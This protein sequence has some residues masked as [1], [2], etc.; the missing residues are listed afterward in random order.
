MRSPFSA[1]SV[2]E[3]RRPMMRSESR[4]EETSGLVTTTATSAWRMACVAPRSMP[5]GLSQM[6]QSNFSRS[7]AMTRATPS[8]VSASLSRVCEAGRIDS[9]STR[10]SRISACTSLAS[11]WTTLMRSKTTRR[12]APITRSRL[13]RPTSKSTT[14]TFCPL[15]AS[16]APRA[17][18][19]VVLPTPPLPDVTTMT[20]AIV[21]TPTPLVQGF[22]RD[23]LAVEARL[24]GATAE[25]P[26]HVLGGL[27]EPVDG[28]ELGLELAA[29]DA[30]PGV[31]HRAGDGAAAQRAVDMDRAA[32]DD[33]GARGDRA[34]D[35]HVALGED[36]RLA[37]AH[38]RLEK[39]RGGPRRGRRGGRRALRAR[40]DAIDVGGGT[41][42]GHR[43]RQ[44]EPQLLR[45]GTLEPHDADAAPVELGDQ[46]RELAPERRQARHV[47]HDG[48]AR[49]EAR[50]ARD[51]GVEPVEPALGRRLG[52][53]HQ[54]HEGAAAKADRRCAAGGGGH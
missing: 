47:D 8:S 5:A 25:L 45:V 19:E 3:S 46:L 44:A 41:P 51:Q 43:R 9:V 23:R 6:T 11:P 12:S 29:I 53:Q 7:S 50:R 14:T 32:G 39:E 28:D 2:L 37:R 52:R 16:A 21:L 36:D 49:E 54:R 42:A 30:G 13:R 38:R 10:L 1:R 24:H 27:V 20:F 15:W 18:V 33:L 17:A 48:A 31:A 26:V 35:R 4:T 22:E 40:L 34:H